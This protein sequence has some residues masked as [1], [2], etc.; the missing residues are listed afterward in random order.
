MRPHEVPGPGNWPCGRARISAVS[1]RE[2]G[3]EK[4][5]P[6]ASD[7]SLAQAASLVAAFVGQ[8]LSFRYLGRRAFTDDPRELQWHRS[9]SREPLE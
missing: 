4:T 7:A 2:S 8:L 5:A 6:I 1:A 3:L 9:P